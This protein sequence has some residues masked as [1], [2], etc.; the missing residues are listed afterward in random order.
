MRNLPG[1]RMT[2]IS[3]LTTRAGGLKR[4]TYALYLAGRAPRTPWYAKALAVLIVAYAASPIDLIPD[5]IP[6]L[7]CLDDLIIVPAG[8]ALF[9]RLIPEDVW[10]EC[11]VKSGKQLR[12][13]RIGWIAGAGIILFWALVAAVILKTVIKQMKRTS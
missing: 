10:A 3:K 8:I 4:Q 5:F 2:F 13:R 12:D 11:R 7:G 1:G 9:I 6:V